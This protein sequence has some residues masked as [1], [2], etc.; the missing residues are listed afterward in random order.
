LL[1]KNGHGVVV[2]QDGQECLE[3]YRKDLRNQ[4]GTQAD[5]PF[6]VIIL[7]HAGKAVYVFT[8]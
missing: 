6:D 8:V 2:A 5:S 1:E 3:K 4:S 7:D